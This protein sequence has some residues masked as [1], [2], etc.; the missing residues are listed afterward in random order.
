MSI[1]V[2]TGPVGTSRA[3]ADGAANVEAG[4]GTHEELGDRLDVPPI[5]AD[6]PQLDVIGI[7]D[8]LV[9]IS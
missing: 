9:S 1:R 4:G 6:Q 8:G 3:A 5:D 2:R 7:V